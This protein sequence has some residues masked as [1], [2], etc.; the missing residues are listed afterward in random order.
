[1]DKD[2]SLVGLDETETFGVIE[3][4]DLTLNHANISFIIAL[5]IASSA[6][7]PRTTAAQLL[8][9]GCSN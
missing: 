3:P 9:T 6:S 5:P 8:V 1:M 7:R 4:S 2:I